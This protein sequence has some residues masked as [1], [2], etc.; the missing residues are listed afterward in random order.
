MP[1]KIAPV[2]Q[3]F[4]YK[5]SLKGVEWDIPPVPDFEDETPGAF[6]PNRSN[7]QEKAASGSNKNDVPATIPNVTELPAPGEPTGKDI[8]LDADS[9]TPAAANSSSV[10]ALPVDSNAAGP[11]QSTPDPKKTTAVGESAVTHTDPVSINPTPGGPTSPSH[12]T[13]SNVA[14]PSTAPVTTVENTAGVDVT[15]SGKK[16]AVNIGSMKGVDKQ[17]LRSA[18]DIL[19]WEELSAEE[20]DNRKTGLANLRHKLQEYFAKEARKVDHVGGGALIEKL[21]EKTLRKDPKPQRLADVQM[22][23]RHYFDKVIRPEYNVEKASADAQFDAWVKANPNASEKDISARKPKGIAIRFEVAKRMLL[24]ETE[25]FQREMKELAD[26]DYRERLEAWEDSAVEVKKPS[27][28]TAQD[29]GASLQKWGPQSATMLNAFGKEMGL[30]GINAW[31]GPN[32]YNNGHIEIFMTSAGTGP[33]GLT[34]SQFDPEAYHAFSRS[35]I[36]FGK[37]IYNHKARAE[38]SISEAEKRGPTI[39]AWGT[40][41]HAA[42]PDR[43]SDE[44]DEDDK[45]RVEDRSAPSGKSVKKSSQK[46]SRDGRVD[47]KKRKATEEQEH[48]GKRSRVVKK[49]KEIVSSSDEEANSDSD[50]EDGPASRTRRAIAR[51][52]KPSAAISKPSAATSKSSAATSKPSA[53]VSKPVTSKPSVVITRSPP[54]RIPPSTPKAA[55]TKAKPPT[56][57]SSKAASSSSKSTP[58]QSKALSPATKKDIPKEY[59]K[60]SGPAIEKDL[61][62]ALK[63]NTGGDTQPQLADTPKANVAETTQAQL[64]EAW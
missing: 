13:D 60:T 19:G 57:S 53:A 12:P 14:E 4:G 17:Q 49:S 44:D 7:K 47:G 58:V 39:R 40:G 61:P 21:A 34:W 63:D 15:S 8:P 43:D 56:T 23:M 22:F 3:K 18:A 24:A 51:A 28:R 55:Q 33:T 25:D 29:W 52:S 45:T 30:V 50:V 64:A 38:R 48:R 54:K 42:I 27:E 1:K 26:K 41:D 37:T 11:N 59:E 46:A 2:T 6:I 36:A 31:V 9:V 5:A 62:E 32:P 16:S 20:V 10:S 35:F